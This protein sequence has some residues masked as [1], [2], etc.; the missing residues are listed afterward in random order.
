MIEL[1]QQVAHNMEQERG[2]WITGDPRVGKSWIAR[3][4]WGAF[5][6]KPQTKWWDGYKG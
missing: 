3:N 6:L 4:A 5:F 1:D 2:I